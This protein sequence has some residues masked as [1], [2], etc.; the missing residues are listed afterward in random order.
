MVFVSGLEDLVLAVVRGELPGLQY[1]LL[2]LSTGHEHSFVYNF[3]R[4]LIMRIKDSTSRQ[5][6]GALM[7]EA[8]SNVKSNRAKRRP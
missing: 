6:L 5:G 3:P 4:E 2:D 7:R 1:R 8:A